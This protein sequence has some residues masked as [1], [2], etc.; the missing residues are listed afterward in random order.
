[1]PGMDDGGAL[2]ELIGD[3][4]GFVSI[5]D[6]RSG[7]LA[8]LGRAVPANW[9]SLNDL[10]PEPEDTAVLITPAFPASAHA[11]FARLAHQNPLVARFQETGDGRAYRFSDVVTPEQLHSLELYREFY[12]PLGLEHQI[13]FT[14]PHPP[15]RLLAVA[16]SRRERDFS[17]DERHLLNQ[18]RPFLIQAYRAANEHSEM[19]SELDRRHDATAAPDERHALVTALVAR[20]LTP[21]EAEVLGWVAL[22]RSNQ[23]AA[24]ELGISDRTVEK[25]LERAYRKLDVPSRSE[26]AALAW[27]LLEL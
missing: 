22:G 25:H 26:A 14:L 20:G 19:R 24:E 12:R 18:A 27:S 6:L 23:A 16:L 2:L 4:V 17:D 8:A 9:I 11:L 13:A 7:M 10:G 15:T 5:E 3:V 21:G 1:M